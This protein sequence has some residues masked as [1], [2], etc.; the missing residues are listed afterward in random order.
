MANAAG[1]AGVSGSDVLVLP[2]SNGCIEGEAAQYIPWFNG[3]PVS[4]R[5]EALEKLFYSI[6][7]GRSSYRIRAVV[8][9]GDHDAME[10]YEQIAAFKSVLRLVWLHNGGK[11][12][13]KLSG[14]DQLPGWSREGLRK[15]KLVYGC[16]NQ[17]QMLRGLDLAI[18]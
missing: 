18:W 4:V 2:H 6:T 10:L 16:T 11:G 7:A 3:K 12:G 13:A 14:Q 9:I 15:L 8:A 1:Y 5:G 17:R